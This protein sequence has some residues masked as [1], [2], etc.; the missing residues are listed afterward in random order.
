MP[1]QRAPTELWRG[2]PAPRGPPPLIPTARWDPLLH[3]PT[4]GRRER[5]GR[6]LPGASRAPPQAEGSAAHP[7]RP[8]PHPCLPG[9]GETHSFVSPGSVMPALPRGRSCSTRRACALGRDV[10]CHLRPPEPG[11]PN[12]SVGHAGGAWKPRG[13][14][15]PPPPPGRL[16]SAREQGPLPQEK[17]GADR[18]FRGPGGPVSTTHPA[19]R[20]DSPRG[21]HARPA[22]LENHGPSWRNFVSLAMPPPPPPPRIL[23]HAAV[24]AF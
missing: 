13:R 17:R 6:G 10:G 14:D 7:W 15:P 9:A 4:A 21:A 12:R 22:D 19:R 11:T 20:D 18:G 8:L 16:S 23:P 2:P 5:M 3:L 1:P 24:S